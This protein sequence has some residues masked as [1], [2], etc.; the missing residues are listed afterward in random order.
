MNGNGTNCKMDVCA[1]QFIQRAKRVVVTDLRDQGQLQRSGAQ[2]WGT[3]LLASYVGQILSL[4]HPVCITTLPLANT[5][6]DLSTTEKSSFSCH[7][8]ALLHSRN[9]WSHYHVRLNTH[10]PL[11]S[12]L[13][14]EH[15]DKIPIY[16][17]TIYNLYTR[18]DSTDH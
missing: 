18:E 5:L 8:S 11:E 10:F 15:N 4:I 9:V 2:S 3:H 7:V 16:K 13:Y 12:K 17:T 1:Q 14:G 6:T